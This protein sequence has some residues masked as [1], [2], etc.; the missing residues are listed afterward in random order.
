MY[1]TLKVI[2]NFDNDEKLLLAEIFDAMAEGNKIADNIRSDPSNL[3][4][5]KFN[6]VPLTSL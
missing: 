1:V 6:F 2:S 3:V 4:M 5:E